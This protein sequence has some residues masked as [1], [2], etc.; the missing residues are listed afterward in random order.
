MMY[1]LT[2]LNL[3]QLQK[4]ISMTLIFNFPFLTEKGTRTK[5]RYMYG[6]N[7]FNW[8]SHGLQNRSRD[9]NH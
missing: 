3:K 5:N 8:K 7:S 2:V 1:L 6:E 9:V 4:Q